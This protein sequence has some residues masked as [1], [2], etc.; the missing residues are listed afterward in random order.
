MAGV[1]SEVGQ[2]RKV[3]VHQP[4][5]EHRRMVPWNREAWLFDDILDIES[6]RPEHKDFVLKMHQHGV[7]VIYFADLLKDVCKDPEVHAQIVGEVVPDG[8]PE[9]MDPLQLQPTNLIMGYPEHFT[10]G[11]QL[12][13]EPAPNLYFMRDPA[14]VVHDHMIISH[15]SR[16]IRCREAN[17]VHAVAK[18]HPQ[19]E[20]LTVYDGILRDKEARIE[21]ATFVPDARHVRRHI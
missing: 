17:L 8:L 18:R 6:A 9:G 20:E 7:D 16:R 10:L 21:G 12:V 3:M 13:L 1:Y 19:F 2:L 11:E 5:W 14:F 4:G 15:P